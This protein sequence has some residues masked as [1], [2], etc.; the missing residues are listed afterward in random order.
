[1]VGTGAKMRKILCFMAAAAVLIGCLPLSAL[2]QE[3]PQE[4]SIQCQYEVNFKIKERTVLGIYD[5]GLFYIPAETVAELTGLHFMAVN[6]QFLFTNQSR[7]H[8][9]YA[10]ERASGTLTCT[11]FWH[12][13][14]KRKIDLYPKEDGMP[15]IAMDQILA[16]MG[17]QVGISEEKGVPTLLVR[18]P[19]TIFDAYQEMDRRL[20]FAL[21]EVGFTQ[22]E[23]ARSQQLN[24]LASFLIDYNEHLFMDALF[25]WW[26]DD[27]LDALEEQV[28]DT[29]AAILTTDYKGLEDDSLYETYTLDNDVLELTDG[30]MEMLGIS[31]KE[32]EMLRNAAK[33][34]NVGEIAMEHYDLYLMYKSM[35]QSQR[36]MLQYTFIHPPQDTFLDSNDTKIKKRKAAAEKAQ[37]YMEDNALSTVTGICDCVIEMAA[38]VLN[39]ALDKIAPVHGIIDAA[40][41]LTKL[42][43]FTQDPLEDNRL[44]TKALHCYDLGCL[45]EKQMV[46]CR[47]RIAEDGCTKQAYVDAFKQALLFQIKTSLTTRKLMLGISQLDPSCKAAMIQKNKDLF[48]MLV[49]VERSSANVLPIEIPAQSCITKNMAENLAPLG[50]ANGEVQKYNFI[51]LMENGVSC[52]LNFDGKMDLLKTNVYN[53]YNEDMEEYCGRYELIIND[54]VFHIEDVRHGVYTNLFLADLNPKDGCLDIILIYRYKGLTAEIWQYD[55]EKLSSTYDSLDISLERDTGEDA[56]LIDRIDLI[57]NPKAGFTF[58]FGEERYTYQ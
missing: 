18:K 40:A 16:A 33:A 47:D 44:L 27:I 58:L 3:P 42:F 55:G 32:I 34:G 36:D 25:S 29:F 20:F 1:M 14:V 4:F 45:A 12:G 39:G 26:N 6:D 5:E 24:I 28:F 17:T 56:D 8:T 7:K 10:L 11:D 22:E 2:A 31:I 23:A 41:T 19:Y 9:Y 53:F 38:M 57:V 54:E 52:D 48:H 46:S 35:A 15:W 13:E 21:S 37:A 43:P 50:A 49:K 51:D 30:M